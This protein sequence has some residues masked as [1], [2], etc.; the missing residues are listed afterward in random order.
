MASAEVSPK[1]NAASDRRVRKA[2]ARDLGQGA[3]RGR[4]A[5]KEGPAAPLTFLE[6]VMGVAVLGDLQVPAA[7]KDRAHGLHHAQPRG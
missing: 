3:H 1:T 5:G 2:E 7:V 6:E 4:E